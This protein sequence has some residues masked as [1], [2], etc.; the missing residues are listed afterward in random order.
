MCQNYAFGGCAPFR[1][2]GI[3]QRFCSSIQ[4]THRPS[5]WNKGGKRCGSDRKGIESGMNEKKE[6]KGKGEIEGEA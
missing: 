5:S 3:L 6:V 1:P 4:S 2:A